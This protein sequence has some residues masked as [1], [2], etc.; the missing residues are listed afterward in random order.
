LS[1]GTVLVRPQLVM[2]PR[3]PTTVR[4]LDLLSDLGV[5]LAR[6][7]LTD[8]D[9]RA[10]VTETFQSLSNGFL[11]KHEVELEKALDRL[12]GLVQPTIAAVTDLTAR[13]DGADPVAIPGAVLDLVA[14]LLGG[15]SAA[16][17]ESA[18]A[19]LLG[20]V[21][22]DLDA[23]VRDVAA[24]LLEPI[25][26][27]L[28]T[29]LQAAHLAG[30][31]SAT[32]VTRYLLARDIVCLRHLIVA[33]VPTF[34]FDRAAILQRIRAVLR[35]LDLDGVA[36]TA[37]TA[38]DVI[39]G[40]GGLLETLFSARLSGSISVAPR[41][42]MGPARSPFAASSPARL[43]ASAS[44]APT[45][46]EPRRYL[47]YA[48]WLLGK[49]LYQQGQLVFEDDLTVLFRGDGMF[50][51]SLVINGDLLTVREQFA[52]HDI[53]LG[54]DLVVVTQEGKPAWTLRDTRN[55]KTYTIV[56]REGESELPV[57][58]GEVFLESDWSKIPLLRGYTFKRAQPPACDLVAWIFNFS[59]DFL[60]MIFHI[61]SAESQDFISNLLNLL[62]H[63]TYGTLKLVGPR[64]FGWTNRDLPMRNP[65][66]NWVL[67]IA[68]TVGASFEGFHLKD[69]GGSVA[70]YWLTLLGADVTEKF[71]YDHWVYML[72]DAVLSV[73]TLLNYDGARDVPGPGTD[74]RPQNR[75]HID[76]TVNLF[77]EGGVWFVSAFYPRSDFGLPNNDNTDKL[78]TLFGHWLGFGLLTQGVSTLLG[79]L[80]AWAL[81]WVVDWPSYGWVNLKASLFTLLKYNIYQY[82]W[83]DGKTSDGQFDGSG[84]SYP[85]YPSDH[86]NSPYKLPY[87]SD[88]T[89]PCAQGNLGVWSHTAHSNESQIYAYDFAMDKG[90]VVLA[91]RDGV[92]DGFNDGFADHNSDDPNFIRIRHD[93]IHPHDQIR[94]S[95]GNIVTVVTYATYLHGLQNSVR[96]VWAEQLG[97]PASSLMP[98]DPLIL[99]QRVTQG[100]P[101]MKA[102]DTGRSAYNHLH[103]HVKP[104][105]GGVEGGYTIPFVFADAGG[106]GRP[107]SLDAYTSGNNQFLYTPKDFTSFTFLSAVNPVLTAD[108]PATLSG[109]AL[110]ATVPGGTARTGL[111]ATFTFL[112]T[113]VTISGTPQV[114]GVTPN[115]FTNPVVYRITASD[116]ST[117]DFTVTVT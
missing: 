71:L 13:F 52:A 19:Q 2:P 32:A 97:V 83:L 22:D 20:V 55:E 64:G 72:R 94:D 100:Q 78:G 25:V 29:R 75:K 48:S 93:A 3:A 51:A 106:D 1:L 35:P 89:Y 62:I 104:Q 60:E 57:Y 112:G 91:C 77:V 21:A 88:T 107:R 114:S 15:L 16:R 37:A 99:N 18:I 69:D 98:N 117:K 38:C 17:V 4:Q 65:W 87:P 92:V 101:I 43:G 50:R 96:E 68:A 73:I 9:T 90:D 30:D 74:T 36:S 63:G 103:L 49:D 66:L 53:R 34:T 110:A 67:P 39:R 56:E 58:E 80:V 102:G 11:R 113:S 95:A 33:A 108:V 81:G 86:E 45:S 31:T 23:I 105:I 44:A 12:L 70:I 46:E 40:L 85:G 41:A 7:L 111:I 79:S 61:A 5:R 28:A 26:D 8:P 42:A 54:T 10:I 47:W 59:G 116:G 76:G 24:G 115:N 82:F 84:D 6:A 14:E 109:T 27:E